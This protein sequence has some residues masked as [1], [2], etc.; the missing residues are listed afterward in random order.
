M[1]GNALGVI[2]G[3]VVVLAGLIAVGSLRAAG[4]PASIIEERQALMKDQ[5]RH[6]K[7]IN[8]ILEN[9]GDVSGVAEHARALAAAAQR[10]PALFPEGTSMDDNVGRTGAKSAIW[11]DWT[12]FEAAAHRFGEESAKLVEV[13]ATGDR[14]AVAEQFVTLGKQGCG[15]CHT[16]FRQKLD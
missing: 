4:D 12:E 6:M 14:A 11:Q 5:G 7:A 9:G 13:A 1:K 3:T 15:N 10:I 8:G 16:P 2:G